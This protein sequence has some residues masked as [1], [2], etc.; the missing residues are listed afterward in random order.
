MGLLKA[1][2][3]DWRKSGGYWMQYEVIGCSKGLV[4]AKHRI[5]V[6]NFCRDSE[7]FKYLEK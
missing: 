4:E 3:G 1:A 7:K 2:R 5:R 6:E